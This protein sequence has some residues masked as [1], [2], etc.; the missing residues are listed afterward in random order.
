M[1]LTAFAYVKTAHTPSTMHIYDRTNILDI[2]YWILQVM[3]L[4]NE[5][6][7]IKTTST[8]LSHG[9]KEFDPWINSIKAGARRSNNYYTKL[10]SERKTFEYWE[11]AWSREKTV[12]ELYKNVP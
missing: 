11:E 7:Q 6:I 10:A 4:R 1:R 2:E 5:M 3:E 8:W 12:R 9:W